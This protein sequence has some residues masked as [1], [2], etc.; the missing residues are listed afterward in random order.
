MYV[1]KV[2]TPDFQLANQIKSVVSVHFLRWKTK[3]KNNGQARDRHTTTI[4]LSKKITG[5]KF[6]ED[7]REQNFA[8]VCF[9]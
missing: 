7:G 1:R 4:Y 5:L 9:N 6:V 3:K 2:H 8:A